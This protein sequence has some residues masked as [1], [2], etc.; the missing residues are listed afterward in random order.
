[1]TPY[2]RVP[3]AARR[4]VLVFLAIAVLSLLPIGSAR[5]DTFTVAAVNFRFEPETRTAAV[6][7]DHGGALTR[8]RGSDRRVLLGSGQRTAVGRLG[9]IDRRDGTRDRHERHG[10][11]DQ[12]EALPAHACSLSRVPGSALLGTVRAGT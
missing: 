4:P 6:G 8:R 7:A 1:M 10:G 9:R 3:A 11:G 12:G 5:A 2:T